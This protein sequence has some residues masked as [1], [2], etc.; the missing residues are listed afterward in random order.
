MEKL[1]GILIFLWIAYWLITSYPI[2]FISV[3]ATI[4]LIFFAIDQNK[5][6]KAREAQRQREQAA[7]EAQLRMEQEEREAQARRHRAEQSAMH[8]Q[9][10]ALV[11][12]SLKTFETMPTELLSA[13]EFLDQSETDFKDG[14]FG[15]FW[16]S[17]EKASMRIGCFDEGVRTITHNASR[18]LQITKTFQSKPPQ[19]PISSDSVR[20]LV[21][22]GTTTDRM[23][24]I[25]RRAQ[26]NYQFATIYEQRKTNKILVAGF[27]N[28]AQA[29]D[30]LGDRIA[31][32][33][34]LLG[35]QISE[36]SGSVSSSL[37]DLNNQVVELNTTFREEAKEQSERH[38]KALEMLDNIQRRRI[39]SAQK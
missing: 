38:N 10:I 39:P 22:A 32:S 3:V 26:C 28:L 27:Q 16:D 29:L 25:V 15:P 30:G 9:L 13:E 5:K 37:S 1:A 31:S 34:D 23:R 12:T 6:R 18:H 21:V 20:K 11:S 7:R 24:A 8:S 2:H 19:F 14:A 4:G 35:N 36:M 33:I 17:V